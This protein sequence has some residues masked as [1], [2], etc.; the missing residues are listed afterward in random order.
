MQ[1]SD[2]LRP[3]KDMAAAWELDLHAFI[4]QYLSETDQA[5]FRDAATLLIGSAQVFAY[6]VDYAYDFAA[7]L[8]S[9]S[10]EEPSAVPHT[11]NATQ[12]RSGGR[13]AF[14]QIIDP[15]TLP[16]LL[17]FVSTTRRTWSGI[18]F[19]DGFT[20]PKFDVVPDTVNYHIVPKQS[21][22]VLA[23]G[24]VDHASLTTTPLYR[25]Y[26]DLISSTFLL[27]QWQID[28][29]YPAL[30]LVLPNAQIGLHSMQALVRTLRS[31]ALNE[32]LIGK[33]SRLDQG[34]PVCTATPLVLC[35]AQRDF[36]ESRLGIPETTPN[37]L[38]YPDESLLDRHPDQMDHPDQID[39]Q[40]L[41]SGSQLIFDMTES[42][43][44]DENDGLV[45]AQDEPSV[46]RGILD[47][48]EFYNALLEPLINIDEGGNNKQAIRRLDTAPLEALRKELLDDLGHM[49][50]AFAKQVLREGLSAAKGIG[51]KVAPK[52]TTERQLA[53]HS[54]GDIDGFGPGLNLLALEPGIG[55]SPSGPQRHQNLELPPT[56]PTTDFETIMQ[57]KLAEIRQRTAAYRPA[58]TVALSSWSTYIGKILCS[59]IEKP[60][61]R[62]EELMEKYSTTTIPERAT[63]SSIC[64][65]EDKCSK[66]DISRAFAAFL[67]LATD[68]KCILE[69]VGSDIRISLV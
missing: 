69:T 19:I 25:A 28:K 40:Q 51:F 22:S 4:D 14:A 37:R 42:D 63:L 60:A 46:K 50:G 57:A 64:L 17:A 55:G 24:A 15:S 31:S 10:E 68:N 49:P 13:T 52:T 1:Y 38:L 30:G 56:T 39:Q 18:E 33:G 58:A 34:N 20:E 61:F 53:P 2:L 21:A 59:E 36:Y 26:R 23:V 9:L 27:E 48:G 62:I 66:S 35:T 5:N 43:P 67:H 16:D 54:S 47:L 12:Q 6:K 8:F 32:S 65:E 29:L 41:S 3:L 11:Q 45:Q 44:I 7:R